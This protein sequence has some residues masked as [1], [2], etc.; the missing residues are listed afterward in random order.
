M[1][2]GPREPPMCWPASH[3]PQAGNVHRLQ[4]R[5]PRG[6]RG[7]SSAN[8]LILTRQPGDRR[9]PSAGTGAV[10]AP[11][12]HPLASWDQVPR[13]KSFHT[14]NALLED[15][16]QPAAWV[17]STVSLNIGKGRWGR[18]CRTGASPPPFGGGRLH[19]R[20]AGWPPALSLPVEK[21]T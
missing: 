8:N 19:L 13:F 10:W 12:S 14:W 21:A 17:S 4:L 11:A 16:L 1:S 5:H 9:T 15:G 18:G 20:R 7:Q 3:P 6:T 2:A